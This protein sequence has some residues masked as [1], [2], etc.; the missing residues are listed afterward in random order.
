MV[1]IYLQKNLRGLGFRW[2]NVAFYC[3][4]QAKV[5]HDYYYY[6]YYEWCTHDVTGSS[7]TG[8]HLVT[9]IQFVLLFVQIY[10]TFPSTKIWMKTL[11]EKVKQFHFYLQQHWRI[12]SLS[13]PFSV[14]NILTGFYDAFFHCWYFISSNENV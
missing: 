6:Y 7:L 2:L 3:W 11:S 5:I 12:G 9:S 13:N 8:M 1:F 14:L 4:G 10:Y